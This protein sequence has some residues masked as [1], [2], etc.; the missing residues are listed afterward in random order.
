MKSCAAGL[1]RNNPGESAAKSSARAPIVCRP[2]SPANTARNAT[3]VARARGPPPRWW[4]RAADEAIGLASSDR[5]ARQLSPQPAAA[6]RASSDV[7]AANLPGGKLDTKLVAAVDRTH[8]QNGDEQLPV[9]RNRS[10]RGPLEKV[11]PWPRSPRTRRR[12][13]RYALRDPSANVPSPTHRDFSRSRSPGRS[14]TAPAAARSSAVTVHA[15][16]VSNTM[17]STGSSRTPSRMCAWKTSRRNVSGALAGAT[18]TRSV[19]AMILPPGRSSRSRAS[20]RVSVD[21]EPNGVGP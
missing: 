20:I 16:G 17:R 19:R 14:S 8:R 21:R 18:I 1:S 4:R 6:S 9:S 7:V 3:P 2:S 12:G 15:I 11:I 5:R 13:R 10:S